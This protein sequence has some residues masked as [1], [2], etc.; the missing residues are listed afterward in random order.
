MKISYLPYK[1]SLIY[2]FSALA[3]LVLLFYLYF[4]PTVKKYELC[5]KFGVPTMKEE[6]VLIVPQ[7]RNFAL[8]EKEYTNLKVLNK[9]TLT[10]K[11]LSLFCDKKKL[12]ELFSYIKE[13]NLDEVSFLL[14]V[15]R[16]I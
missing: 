14:Y 16:F 5:C 3:I 8:N 10:Q 13:Q 11:E 1:K 2:T 6:F 15:D 12:C 9:N 4:K 7:Q